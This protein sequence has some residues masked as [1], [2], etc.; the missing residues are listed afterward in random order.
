MASRIPKEAC[1]R[2]SRGA[3]FWGREREEI[4]KEE[5]IWTDFYYAREIA[6]GIFSYDERERD[7]ERRICFCQRKCFTKRAVGF[8]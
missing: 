1:V 7:G 8:L 6:V 3:L 5:K 4:R 2:E